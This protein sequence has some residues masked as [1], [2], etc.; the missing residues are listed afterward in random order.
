VAQGESEAIN[1]MGPQL[2]SSGSVYASQTAAYTA[3]SSA[4]IPIPGMGAGTLGS[5]AR[6]WVTLLP[7]GATTPDVHI[8]FGDAGMGAATTS[9]S[10]F[11]SGQRE[12][13]EVPPGCTGFRMIG[14][15]SAGT[16]YWHRSG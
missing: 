6:A 11:V 1:R 2:S 10:R 9:D 5:G 4:F 7:I 12:D 13:F 16:L 8:A 14:N 3:A 15:T